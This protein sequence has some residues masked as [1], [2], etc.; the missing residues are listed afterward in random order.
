MIWFKTFIFHVIL[1]LLS[2]PVFGINYLTQCIIINSC[3]LTF[4]LSILI[5]IRIMISLGIE[6]VQDIVDIFK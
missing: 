4:S 5:V 3:L 6:I 2:V 1:F